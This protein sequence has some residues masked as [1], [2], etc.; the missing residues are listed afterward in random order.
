MRRF[1]R[2]F[3][4][5]VVVAS[6]ASLLGFAAPASAA[7]RP[8]DVDWVRTTVIVNPSNPTEAY[9]QAR[10][11]CYDGA[12]ANHLWVSVKQGP[13]DLTGEGSSSVSTAW[14]D[15]HP[16]NLLCNGKWQGQS[17]TITQHQGWGQ[18]VT[19]PGYL[20]FCLFPTTTRAPSSSSTRTCRCIGTAGRPSPES[21]LSGGVGRRAPPPAR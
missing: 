12:A 15:A 20:Q 21:G 11:R 17:F 5:F 19:G 2:T 6:T 13:G 3:G 16:S 7:T 9:V 4:L 10:Y 18:L 1:R 8:P 14:Y